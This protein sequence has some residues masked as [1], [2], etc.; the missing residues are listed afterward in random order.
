MC[1]YLIFWKKEES[2]S[3]VKEKDLILREER[4]EIGMECEVK[5]GGKVLQGVLAGI[6]KQYVQ[7]LYLN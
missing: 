4:F 1:Y 2:V 5:Y 3:V 6:G 7:L